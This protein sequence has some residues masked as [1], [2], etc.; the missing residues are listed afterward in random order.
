MFARSGNP[1]HTH[2]RTPHMSVDQEGD[3]APDPAAPS[4]WTR[5]FLAL[6]EADRPDFQW[7]VLPEGLPA[8]V[9]GLL[10]AVTLIAVGVRG[11]R[12]LRCPAWVGEE[13]PMG[14]VQIWPAEF[15]LEIRNNFGT[16]FGPISA[17]PLFF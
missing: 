6:I 7:E 10:C 2:A 4:E 12:A 1:L 8:G 13:T 9:L 15:C 16:S 17:Q 5:V 14:G 11:T 3:L